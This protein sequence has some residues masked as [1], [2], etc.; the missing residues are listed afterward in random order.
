MRS[1]WVCSAHG[2]GDGGGVDEDDGGGDDGY[3]ALQTKGI[4]LGL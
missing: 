4:G 2:C 1:C 3:V